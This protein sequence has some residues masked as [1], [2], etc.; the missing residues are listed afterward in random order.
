MQHNV[1][2][3]IFHMAQ[4]S[5]CGPVGRCIQSA[6]LSVCAIGTVCGKFSTPAVSRSHCA[7]F[8][9]HVAK[10]N[11]MRHAWQNGK[12]QNCTHLPLFGV[13]KKFG[14]PFWGPKTDNF[15]TVAKHDSSKNFLQ[16]ILLIN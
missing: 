15:N 8:H 16:N 2:T 1:Q 11:I 6:A 9:A 4:Y 13:K 10:H 14:L 5:V 12:V 3:A 7:V